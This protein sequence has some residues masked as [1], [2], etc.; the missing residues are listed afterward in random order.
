MSI[1]REGG[2][3]V[4]GD[5]GDRG[6]HGVTVGGGGREKWWHQ[7]EMAGAVVMVQRHH[8]IYG[9]T[10]T[11]LISRRLY[12]LGLVLLFTRG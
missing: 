12:L 5:L 10:G 9:G 6:P 7:G 8:P 2:G 11:H 4:N 3:V 1:K